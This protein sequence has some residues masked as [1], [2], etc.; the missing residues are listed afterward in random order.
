MTPEL[1]QGILLV[2]LGLTLWGVAA[3]TA[4]GRTGRPAVVE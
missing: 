4:G 3:A 2:A 1:G